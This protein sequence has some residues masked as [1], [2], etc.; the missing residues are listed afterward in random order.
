MTLNGH[1]AFFILGQI[2]SFLAKPILISALALFALF[3]FLPDEQKTDVQTNI[4]TNTL[5]TTN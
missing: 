2:M 3:G 4:F 1:T 5:I